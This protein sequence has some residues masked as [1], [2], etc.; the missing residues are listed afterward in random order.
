M[1]VP[2]YR[3]KS[4]TEVSH[5]KSH[6]YRLSSCRRN[7]KTNHCVAG[8]DL[9]Q[10]MLSL[11]PLQNHLYV[12]SMVRFDC[13]GLS[14]G[15]ENRLGIKLE[16]SAHRPSPFSSSVMV[17]SINYE[18]NSPT[19]LNPGEKVNCFALSQFAMILQ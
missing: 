9:S 3:M 10:I 8:Y 17:I 7:E 11:H 5:S 6:K 2:H 16:Q 4:R 18:E 12:N 19:C 14:F 15:P 13:P 1:N